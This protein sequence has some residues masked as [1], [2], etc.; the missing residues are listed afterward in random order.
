MFVNSLKGFIALANFQSWYYIRP[1]LGFF[2]FYLGLH[3][4]YWHSIS[5]SNANLTMRRCVILDFNFLLQICCISFSGCKILLSL[6]PESEL[7]VFKCHKELLNQAHDCHVKFVSFLLIKK[8][9]VCQGITF[10]H[11]LNIF[12]PKNIKQSLWQWAL[13]KETY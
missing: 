5:Q 3:H 4:N 6:Y 1:L 11:F 8:N 7:Y 12:Y 9:K 13:S 10:L 2:Y